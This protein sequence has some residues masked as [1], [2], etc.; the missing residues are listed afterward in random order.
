[1]PPALSSRVA[2]VC[3]VHAR[4]M[5]IS[6][7]PD[8]LVAEA[9]PKIALR[10]NSR[11]GRILSKLVVLDISRIEASHPAVLALATVRYQNFS[12]RTVASAHTAGRN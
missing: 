10:A 3:A 7:F 4:F 6:R 8:F 5:S 9:E 11:G 2:L 12:Y 1:M